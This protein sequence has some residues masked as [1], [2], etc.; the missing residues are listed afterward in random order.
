MIDDIQEYERMERNVR[1]AIRRHLAQCARAELAPAARRH[2]IDSF[3]TTD[4][5]TT[6]LASG[7]L[8][9]ARLAALVNEEVTAALAS[10]EPGEGAS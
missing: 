7:L 3:A 8:S 9:P 1:A 5:A 6:Y 4:P 10:S 2:L